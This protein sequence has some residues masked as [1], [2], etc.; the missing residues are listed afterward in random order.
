[1]KTVEVVATLAGLTEEQVSTI[2]DVVNHTRAANE[3]LAGLEP[4]KRR[5]RK[6]GVKNVVKA[7]AKVVPAPAKKSAAKKSGGKKSSIPDSFTE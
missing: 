6:P 2:V 3:A 4:K 5:G 7:Q 1:M